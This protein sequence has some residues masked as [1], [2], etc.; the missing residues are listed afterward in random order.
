MTPELGFVISNKVRDLSLTE[1]HYR[2]FLTRLP[3]TKEKLSASQA[4][5]LYPFALILFYSSSM[6]LAKSLGEPM[7]RD[8]GTI[9]PLMTTS[10][11]I[12]AE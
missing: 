2:G 1:T 7:A 10:P 3:V 9:K 11:Q 8:I 6:R 5:R 4:L 12:A